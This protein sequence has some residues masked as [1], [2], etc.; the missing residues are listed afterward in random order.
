[1]VT[2]TEVGVVPEQ[3]V[4]PPDTVYVGNGLIVTVREC[5]TW[6]QVLFA[7][8]SWFVIVTVYVPPG[9]ALTVAEFDSVGDHVN[10]Y[11]LSI[12]CAAVPCTKTND[13]GIGDFPVQ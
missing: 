10:T 13:V 6:V 5:I 12:D 7:P 2:V 11:P 1:M 8:A 3:N 4:P 9:N